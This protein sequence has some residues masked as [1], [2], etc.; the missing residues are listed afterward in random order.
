MI[1]LQGDRRKSLLYLSKRCLNLLNIRKFTNNEKT[2]KNESVLLSF[3]RIPHTMIIFFIIIIFFFNWRFTANR[4]L[5]LLVSK[6]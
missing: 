4:K 3:S 2:I 5:K 1:W 6:F